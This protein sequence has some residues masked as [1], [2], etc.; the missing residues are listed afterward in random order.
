MSEQI[1]AKLRFDVM[2]RDNF[3]CHY[4]GRTGEQVELEVDHIIPVAKGGKSELNNLVT[5]CKECN[6]G[7]RDTSVLKYVPIEMRTRRVQIILPPSLYKKA[8][9]SA[10]DNNISFN[11]YVIRSLEKM[12]KHE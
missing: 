10:Q 9:E 8:K 3:R 1:P 12:E 6:R 4:C 5:A 7:K 11:E 2:R